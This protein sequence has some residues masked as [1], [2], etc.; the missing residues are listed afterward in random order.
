MKKVFVIA[1]TKGGVGKT[2]IASHIMSSVFPGCEILEI[3]DNNRSDIFKNSGYIKRFE[4]IKVNECENKLEEL[5]FTLLEDTE[6]VLII[7]AGG[8][9][10]TKSVL[11]AIQDLDLKEIAKV[12]YIVPIMNSFVQA[13]N[14]VDMAKILKDE[15]II[16]ALNAVEDISKIKQDWLFW[17]GD[18]SLGLESYFEKLGKPQTVII[19]R[20]S[21]FELASLSRMTISDFAQQARAVD[22][23]TFQ[24]V[25]FNEHK[26]NKELYLKEL[27]EFRA[28]KRSKDFLD[29]FI[30]TIKE[31]LEYEI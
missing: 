2:T 16:F 3:D 10:D 31:E 7:D 12:T 13:K 26:N 14:A 1:S 22:L 24:K 21:F 6:D 11:K 5:T 23:A 17:F 25:A 19:P 9:N 15:N 28:S 18:E 4:S 30:D 20:S 8:G 27:R 29:S